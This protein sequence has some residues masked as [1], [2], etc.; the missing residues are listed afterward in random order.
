MVGLFFDFCLCCCYTAIMKTFSTVEDYLEVIAG[1]RNPDG[2]V[3]ANNTLLFMGFYE[4]K[5]IISLARYDVSFL[6][7]V[8]D[9]TLGGAALTDR[10]AELALK[11]IAKYSRQLATQQIDTG[12]IAQTPV[13][14]KPLR[15]VDRTKTVDV[16]NGEI[17]V[18]FPYEQ[19]LIDFIRENAKDSQ[20]RVRFD[21]EHK[22]WRVGFTEYNV[23][24]VYAF[25]QQHEFKIGAALEKAMQEILTVERVPY[26]IELVFKNGELHILNAPVSMLEHLGNAHN[27]FPMEQLAT[28]VDMAPV[29]GY[30]IHDDVAVEYTQQF[31]SDTAIML[32]DRTYDFKDYNWANLERSVLTYAELTNRFPIVV[33]DPQGNFGLWEQLVGGENVLNL[34]KV[35]HDQEY[36]VCQ[37]STARV[38]LCNRAVKYLDR[39]PLLISNM[40]MI[41]GQDK[42]IMLDASEKVFYRNGK[43]T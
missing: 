12:A 3:P 36:Q 33:F 35:K 11:I 41:V 25:A 30:T 22:A 6:D 28:L 8:T 20:G 19:K 9:A 38:I 40:G 32:R 23:N 37:T 1:K 16:K 24:W 42:R 13:Y 34:T 31:G 15:I 14:R 39:I 4:F 29:L 5:P 27:Q 10:Q 26:V 2:S 43:L 18:H 17:L 21:K 7:S